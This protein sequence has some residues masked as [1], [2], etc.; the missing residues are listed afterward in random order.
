MLHPRV[1]HSSMMWTGCQASITVREKGR[2]VH[3]PVLLADLG[4]SPD[5]KGDRLQY[6]CTLNLQ[7]RR[8]PL[9]SG[10]CFCCEFVN[11]YYGIMSWGRS[12]SASRACWP[13][14]DMELMMDGLNLP[15]SRP[16]DKPGWALKAIGGAALPMVPDK[17]QQSLGP[18]SFP[19]RWEDLEATTSLAWSGSLPVKSF[20][21]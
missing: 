19:R 2:S 6:L 11:K 15:Q 9:I 3:C 8:Y 1:R 13:L 10:G 17:S 20:P 12:F 7:P 18:Y 14:A 21:S 4:A 16:Q 5:Q